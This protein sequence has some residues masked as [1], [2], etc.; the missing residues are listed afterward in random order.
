MI[1]HVR[2]YLDASLARDHEKAGSFL[3]LPRGQAEIY[4]EDIAKICGSRIEV[5]L[6]RRP[7]NALNVEIGQALDRCAG[8]H[9]PEW[10]NRP[11]TTPST[12]RWLASGGSPLVLGPCAFSDCPKI[13][14]VKP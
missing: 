14:A 1:S 3:P 13:Q 8:K 6:I 11:G 12:R 10:K 5:A 4:F 2:A 7:G 9:P